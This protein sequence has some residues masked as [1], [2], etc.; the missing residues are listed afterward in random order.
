MTTPTVAPKT[1]HPFE[2]AGL[3]KAPFKC[4]GMSENVFVIPGFGGGSKAGGSC[5]YCGT[6]IRYEYHIVSSDG[7]KFHVGCDCVEKVSA[8]GS[9]LLTEAEKVKRDFDRNKREETR[10]NKAE[11]TLQA[12]RDTNGGL[13]NWELAQKQ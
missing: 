9:R 2:A 4:T 8:K 12:Q 3:G 5:Q 6:G 11:A 1:I 7:K 10:R 13:T